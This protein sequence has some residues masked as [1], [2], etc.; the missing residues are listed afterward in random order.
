MK[1]QALSLNPF[2]PFEDKTL[3]FAP[4]R[5][6]LVYG[7]NEAGKSSA[8]RALGDFLYGV[9]T[10]SIDNFRFDYRR[11][12]LSGE[13]LLA[14]GTR[15]ELER[16]KKAKDDLRQSGGQVVSEQQM[17]A[18]LSHTPRT[19]FESLFGI[20][21]DALREGSEAILQEDGEI[22]RILFAAASGSRHLAQTQQALAEEA[23]TLY[24][25]RGKN[26]QLN[27]ALAAWKSAVDELKSLQLAASEFE[28]R[29]HALSVTQARLEEA[30]QALAEA[31]ARHAEL[32]ALIVLKPLLARYDEVDAQVKRVA[33][34]PALSD[35][36]ATRY[37][38]VQQQLATTRS[39]WDQWQQDLQR[40]SEAMP[41][42]APDE[43]LLAS[44]ERIESLYE[45]LASH[46]DAEADLAELLPEVQARQE[47]YDRHCQPLS[48]EPATW[49]RVL[50]GRSHLERLADDA[51]AQRQ[52]CRHLAQQRVQID[53]N[54]ARLAPLKADDTQADPTPLE[55]ALQQALSSQ[56]ISEEIDALRTQ[57]GVM[58][59]QL[60]LDVAALGGWRGTVDE[61]L[62]RAF[63]STTWL[64]TFSAELQEI[65][66]R[67]QADLQRVEE[68]Q[69]RK[70]AASSRYQLL[71]A[72][73]KTPPPSEL[74]TLRGDRDTAWLAIRQG[75]LGEAKLPRESGLDAFE[76]KVGK[77]D[78]LADALR[79]NADWVSQLALAQDEADTVSV[80]LDK[81][82][83]A[84]RQTSETAA[85]KQQSWLDAW[86]AC[87]VDAG[88]VSEMRSWL[89]A[90][91][92]IRQDAVAL[93]EK[94]Q[95]LTRL[96]EKRTQLITV[97]KHALSRVGV[98]VEDDTF[99]AALLQ[100]RETLQQT[101]S[102]LEARQKLQEQHDTLA[103]QHAV[104]V[105]EEAR[106]D[107]QAEAA[108]QAWR[109]GAPAE[110]PTEPEDL[111]A[112]L[113]RLEKALDLAST[114]H[115]LRRRSEALQARLARFQQEAAPL[116]TLLPES[117]QALPL[118]GQVSAALRL[119][120]E[121]QA[122]GHERAR[123]QQLQQEL[124][125]KMQASEAQW[126]ELQAV[127]EQV[128]QEAGCDSV[129]E[130]P[131]VIER[132]R[133]KRALVVLRAEVEAQINQHAPAQ[134]L[135]DLRNAVAGVDLAEA[136][137]ALP[138]LTL[139]LNEELEPAYEQAVRDETGA[140]RE[141]DALQ[142]DDAAAV[143]ALD[144]SAKRAEARELAARYLRLKLAATLLARETE[145]FRQQHQGPLLQKASTLFAQLTEGAF[146]EL[147]VDTDGKRVLLAA[148]RAGTSELVRV[149]GMSS[150]T[151]DQL[152]LALRLASLERYVADNGPVPFIVDDILIE[153]D[154]ARTRAALGCLKAFAAHTQ[155]VL[156]THHRHVLEMASAMG[157]IAIEQL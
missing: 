89:A 40:L 36:F 64:E 124:Q 101:R 2:G 152:Y 115:S 149:D 139:R 29:R 104:L 52:Q 41:Q 80:A 131:A 75:I 76:S 140:K 127:L 45:S 85:E 17:Q 26:Q 31:K 138:Q 15:V 12:K 97:L 73:G 54:R 136:Q 118:V 77:A 154:D 153:F 148:K 91:A 18:W 134:P 69:A 21:H 120:R 108:M 130:I 11:L 3:C 78:A 126:R 47:E 6:T 68:H 72:Q 27:A 99:D 46:R 5:L 95:S 56:H 34:V 82:V 42:D 94:R 112:W 58:A 133:E 132:A 55:L 30:R 53:A 96:V 103:R 37:Q 10:R 86:S 87:G 14:D 1:L 98:E 71:K 7:A 137:A 105:T 32:Q 157:D 70:E 122:R 128:Q 142:G 81:A 90:L 92:Q 20:N 13:I 63:P 156:F 121:E 109:D 83:E 123:Q 49:Q 150:G 4:D 48:G 65:K 19:V 111:A 59:R 135:S 38:S 116:S 8:L 57:T 33:D 60:E 117:M 114:L 107:E 144:V 35:D 61:L 100:A 151:R 113:H 24:K 9:P 125:E 88:S 62:S 146:S 28:A 129:A 145:R 155:V 119:L 141:M 22:G 143:L 51:L 66:A 110:A 67:V 84:L 106:A 79:E 43:T 74:Q 23:E 147:D 39:H 50:D 44:A 93:E 16:Q 102:R 25:P